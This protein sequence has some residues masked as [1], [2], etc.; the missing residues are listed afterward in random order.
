M[1]KDPNQHELKFLP[2]TKKEFN[3]LL[4]PFQNKCRFSQLHHNH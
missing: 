1:F 4:H 3:L 2:L